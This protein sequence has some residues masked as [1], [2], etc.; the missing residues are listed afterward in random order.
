MVEKQTEFS[1]KFEIFKALIQHSRSLVVLTGAG[2]ST[3]SGIPDFRSSQ[4]VSA[5]RWNGYRVE[6]ILSISLFRKDPSLFYAWAREVWYQLDSYQPNSVHHML[7]ILEEKGYIQG[8]FTQNIDMLHTKA[9]SKKCYELHG[10]ALHHHCTFCNSYYT[11]SQI[12]PIVMAGEVPLCTQCN[13]VIKPD[14][15]LYG[16]NL[17]PLILSRSYEMFRHTDLCLVLG[18]SLVVQPAASLPAYALHNGAPIVVAN[19]QKTS[20]DGSATVHFS[21]LKQLS[22][23]ML[24]WLETLKPRNSRL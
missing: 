15:V 5:T 1:K 7:A 9:G 4:G 3:L 16:E 18:S 2:V 6:D 19:A 8:L 10:S 11:Y 14:I 17:D 21:D 24:V 20:Y 12:Q 13:H 22:E 23:A